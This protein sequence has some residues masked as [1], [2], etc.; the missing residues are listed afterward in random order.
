MS[1]N[2]FQNL[3][4]PLLFAR[5]WRKSRWGGSAA[6]KRNGDPRRHVMWKYDFSTAGIIIRDRE[7]AT[8]RHGGVAG[9]I[10]RECML[11]RFHGQSSIEEQ[12]QLVGEASNLPQCVGKAK[13][14]DFGSSMR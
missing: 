10:Y 6:S 2:V 1:L 11:H 9:R 3:G 14:E 7:M 12:L 4:S 5:F 8:W 13:M